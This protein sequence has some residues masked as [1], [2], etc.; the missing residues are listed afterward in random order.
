[1]AKIVLHLGSNQG[2]RQQEIQRA[3][4]YIEGSIG[5]IKLTSSFYETEAWGVEDQPSFFNI[6]LL[7]HTTLLPDQ[8]LKVVLGIENKMGRQRKQHWGQRLIDIDILFYNDWQ[9]NFPE[10]I[11]PHPRIQDRHFVLSP[12]MEIMPNFLHPKLKKTI[13]Q[14]KEACTDKLLVKKM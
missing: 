3:I 1:M 12:L 6:A 8:L 4:T 2:N 7:L 10:L 9:I 14:L 11:I 13:T 5:D